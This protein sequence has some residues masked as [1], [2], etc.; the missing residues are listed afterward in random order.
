M[1]PAVRM[2]TVFQ[3]RQIKPSIAVLWLGEVHDDMGEE[4]RLLTQID[5]R[6]SGWK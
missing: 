3:E 2:L 5:R 1:A 6:T 4:Y